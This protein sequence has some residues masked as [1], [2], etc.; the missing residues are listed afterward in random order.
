MCSFDLCGTFC[1]H[2]WMQMQADTLCAMH[3]QTIIIIEQIG[4]NTILKCLLIYMWKLMQ[5]DASKICN[6]LCITFAGGTLA[7]RT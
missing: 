2:C 3:H 4:M 6:Q 7:K 1:I 5:F